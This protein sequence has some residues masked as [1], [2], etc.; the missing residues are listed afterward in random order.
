MIFLLTSTKLAQVFL[1]STRNQ[2]SVFPQTFHGPSVSQDKTPTIDF[3][4]TIV[5]FRLSNL[6][7]FEISTFWL[8]GTKSAD[9]FLGWTGNQESTL[10][11]TFHGP[12]HEF[13]L[14]TLF[15]L[16]T[17][18]GVLS[19]DTEGLWKAENCPVFSNLAQKELENLFG[20]SNK[21]EISN[22]TGWFYLK[23][24]LLEQ[25]FG[26]HHCIVFHS[27]NLV[28]TPFNASH[29]MP[30]K[31]CPV[32]PFTTHYID[33]PCTPHY[34]AP[35]FCAHLI[36]NFLPTSSMKY[37]YNRKR[38]RRIKWRVLAIDIDR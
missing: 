24:R 34:L 14:L 31:P 25:C 32:L 5:P 15:D 19:C 10:P 28:A 20:V 12:S 26:L 38:C 7:K 27:I 13:N 11:Q 1:G 3:R 8:A 16:V 36:L 29:P 22:F 4:W 23:D 2:E 30:S 21:G 9:F 17:F 37:N 35:R 18:T 6:I 33:T